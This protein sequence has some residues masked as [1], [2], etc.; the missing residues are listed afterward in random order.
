VRKYQRGRE[1]NNLPLFLRYAAMVFIKLRR[2]GGEIFI[3]SRSWL[4][5]ERK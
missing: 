4:V 3:D 5:S 1:T 2:S